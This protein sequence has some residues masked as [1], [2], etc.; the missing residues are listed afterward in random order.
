MAKVVGL[1]LEISLIDGFLLDDLHARFI[2]WLF[3]HGPRV[4]PKKAVLLLNAR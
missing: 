2:R 3:V 1:N 4:A